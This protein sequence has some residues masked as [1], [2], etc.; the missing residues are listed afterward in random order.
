MIMK[1][2]LTKKLK[3]L[4]AGLLA[5][6]T[7]L[8][9]CACELPGTEINYGDKDNSAY[10]AHI[11]KPQEVTVDVPEEKPDPGYKE[12]YESFMMNFVVPNDFDKMVFFKG[13]VLQEKS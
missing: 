12:T 1:N 4:L 2:G 13:R 7:A 9:F 6:G 5:A 10:H 3:R 8:I 11:E